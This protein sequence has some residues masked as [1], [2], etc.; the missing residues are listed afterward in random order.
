M[1]PRKVLISLNCTRMR[2][3]GSSSIVAGKICVTSNPPKSA[4]LPKKRKRESA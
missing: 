1:S 2:K 3:I 4:S